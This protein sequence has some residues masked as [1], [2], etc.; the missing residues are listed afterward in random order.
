MEYVPTQVVT[1]FVRHRMKYGENTRFDGIIY[2][3]SKS[4]GGDAVVI[5][6]GPENCIEPSFGNEQLLRLSNVLEY[7]TNDFKPLFDST[8]AES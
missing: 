1:E 5:F 4:G 3:S 6:A 8:S 2:R 7:D